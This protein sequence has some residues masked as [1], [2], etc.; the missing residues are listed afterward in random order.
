VKKVYQYIWAKAIDPAAGAVEIR[1]RYDF[2]NLKDLVRCTWSV[3]GDGKVLQKGELPPLDLAPDA[4]AAVKIPLE[5]VEAKP[6]VEYWLALSFVLAADQPWAPAG[7]E[8]AWQQFRL[9]APLPAAPADLA[10]AAPTAEEDAV[11]FKLTAGGVTATVERAS[12]A[13]ASLIWEGVELVHAPLHPHFWRAPIDND[14]GAED[15]LKEIQP[16]QRAGAEWKPSEVRLDMSRADAPAVV[17]C[18][19]VRDFGSLAVTWRMLA[20]GDLVVEQ[21][22]T[23]SRKKG[24]PEMPRFGMQMALPAGFETLRWY[25]PGPH[26]TYCD[27]KDARVGVYESTVEDQYFD[28]TEPGE[29]GNHADARWV[30]LCDAKGNGLL[31]IGQ[32]LL[33]VNALHYSTDDLSST[34]HGWEMIRRDFVTLNLDL[35]QMGVGGINSWGAIPAD[36]ARIS[37]AQPQAYRYLLRP[38]KGGRETILRLAHRAVLVGK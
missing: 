22:W 5:P 15:Y 28:Y 1:N 38:F 27:R 2:T 32:P 20:S 24:A 23:P 6:G 16:W 33:S 29:T 19:N 7:H 11:T 37:A 10:A 12:G 26:E 14:R 36:A 17:A 30:A 34:P 4:T 3:T 25:G 13:L 31:A 9:Q 18:G 35:K 21:A 8:V